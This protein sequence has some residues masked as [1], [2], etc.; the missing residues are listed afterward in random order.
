M[1]YNIDTDVNETVFD[2]LKPFQEITDAETIKELM[3]EPVI[4]FTIS[5]ISFYLTHTENTLLNARI[6]LLH[7]LVT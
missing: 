2:D 6:L 1:N 4:L 7:P 5:T 3:G